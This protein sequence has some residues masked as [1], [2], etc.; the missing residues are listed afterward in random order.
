MNHNLQSLRALA[1]LA[2]LLFHAMPFFG[3]VGGQP[4]ALGKA[5][6][7]GY[8]GVDL[9]FVISGFIIARGVPGCRLASADFRHFV[10]RRAYR[11]FL[12]YWPVLAL[13]CLYYAWAMPERLAQADPRATLFLLSHRIPDLVIGQAW[14]LSFEL[15]FYLLFGV[16]A[17]AGRHAARVVVLIYALVIVVLNLRDPAVAKGFFA[18]PHLL[19]LFAGMLL[20]QADIPAAWRRRVM[21]LALAAIALFGIWLSLS[22]PT[23]L[24]TVSLVGTA[25]LLL[26]LIAELR[27]Q[28]GHNPPSWLSMLGDSSYAL[29]LLHYLLLEI[30]VRHLGSIEGLRP[31]LPYLFPFWLAAIVALAHGHYRWLERPLF[32]RVCALRG[33][34]GRRGSA[35]AWR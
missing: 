8:L 1:A 25:A 30:F 18:N 9:F 35:G 26:V 5:F 23:R 28:A 21:Q 16:L 14:S 31:I 24:V 3:Q 10:E 4:G 7:V 15:Y 34:P 32:R 27:Y 6:G 17:L 29:Y 19:E 2:V 22:S 33:L 11:I 20:G 12:G 13:A